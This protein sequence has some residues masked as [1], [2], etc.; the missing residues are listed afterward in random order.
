MSVMATEETG[1]HFKPILFHAETSDENQKLNA[2]MSLSVNKSKG[3]EKLNELHFR[4]MKKQQNSYNI[5]LLL[6][7]QQNMRSF[8]KGL[9]TIDGDIDKERIEVKAKLDT[10]DFMTFYATE[11]KSEGQS[12][13]NFGLYNKYG[14]DKLNIREN[15]NIRITFSLSYYKYIYSS[16]IPKRELLKR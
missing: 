8:K 1:E 13:L 14:I 9:I 6:D 4:I 2:K 3:F 15:M 12:S 11:K 5:Q 10:D 16:D 7:N